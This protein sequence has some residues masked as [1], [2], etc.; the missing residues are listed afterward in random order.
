M[1]LSVLGAGAAFF[2]GPDWL[3]SA[4]PSSDPDNPDHRHHD[5]HDDDDDGLLAYHHQSYQMMMM[6]IYI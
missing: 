6:M 1:K 3:G 2:I 5:E 4:C